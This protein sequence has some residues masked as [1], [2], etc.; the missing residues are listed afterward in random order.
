MAVFAAV[1]VCAVS[2][3]F[4]YRTGTQGPATPR[5]AADQMLRSMGKNSINEFEQ[6]LCEPKRNQAGAILREFNSGLVEYG[7]TLD[8]L[9]WRVTKE[10][11]VSRDEV[12]LDLDVT[13]ATLET[14]TGKRDRRPFPM[15]LQALQDHGWYICTIK[16]LAL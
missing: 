12:S 3:V 16:I 4:L 13:L 5:A 10:T 9:T 8:D 15:R 7:Q 14:R 6:S 2:V 11:N 1:V